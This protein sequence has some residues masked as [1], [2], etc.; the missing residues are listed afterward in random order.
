MYPAL[1]A[2]IRLEH[3]GA[4]DYCRRVRLLSLDSLNFRERIDGQCGKVLVSRSNE[5]SVLHFDALLLADPPRQQA[6]KRVSLRGVVD[7][8]LARSGSKPR[9]GIGRHGS[10]VLSGRF[11][12]ERGRCEIP[13][14]ITGAKVYFEDS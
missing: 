9:I 8:T 11:E 10:F 1:Q 2:A 6:P 3:Y 4:A 14:F 5:P 7:Q 13:L 12:C